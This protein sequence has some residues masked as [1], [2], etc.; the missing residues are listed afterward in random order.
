MA[1]QLHS[2]IAFGTHSRGICLNML[3]E[4]VAYQLHRVIFSS[5]ACHQPSVIHGSQLLPTISAPTVCGQRHAECSNGSRTR[6]PGHWDDLR[7][8]V[9]ALILIMVSGTNQTKVCYNRCTNRGTK[10]LGS[11]R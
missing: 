4:K 11:Q 8:T 6:R 5:T 7:H 10:L 1:N 9:D 2:N 3:H